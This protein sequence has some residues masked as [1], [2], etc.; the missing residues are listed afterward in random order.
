DY[1]VGLIQVMISLDHLDTAQELVWL[2]DKK[3]KKLAH[4]SGLLKLRLS[5]LKRE[6]AE[7]D[8]ISIL[9]NLS[10]SYKI[11]L[12]SQ[13]QVQPYFNVLFDNYASAYNDGK[14]ELGDRELMVLANLYFIKQDYNSA[15]DIIDNHG[16][17]LA[18]PR[19]QISLASLL[20][21]LPEESEKIIVNAEDSDYTDRK[22]RSVSKPN[23]PSQSKQVDERFVPLDLSE[24]DLATPGDLSAFEKLS[25]DYFNRMKQMKTQAQERWL[26]EQ[27]NK[28]FFE[29][30]SHHMDPTKHAFAA[31][32]ES[33]KS[34]AIMNDM[35][36]RQ[37]TYENLDKQNSKMFAGRLSKIDSLL[38][39]TN[40]REA[41]I[42]ILRDFRR[43]WSF[44]QNSS[45]PALKG[46][47]DQ[48]L[49]SDEGTSLLNRVKRELRE[50]N[51]TDGRPIHTGFSRKYQ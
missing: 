39:S 16:Y 20:S 41:K 24:L 27:V 47:W 33:E 29:M 1:K 7:T 12:L 3:N 10:A 9:D 21:R 26:Y 8:K 11:L 42:K 25:E 49:R 32:K 2:L 31:F 34:Q 19:A 22:F 37:A 36:K 4:Y 6:V 43:N 40:D 44:Y 18:E 46:A 23:Q 45:N 30:W 17:A 48:Y 5:V 28:K 14:L 51:L 15:R 38:N 13:E 35:A 50:H